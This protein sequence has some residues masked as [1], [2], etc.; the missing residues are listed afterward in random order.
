MFKKGKL[1][2]HFIAPFIKKQSTFEEMH[3]RV[4]ETQFLRQYD[5][6]SGQDDLVKKIKVLFGIGSKA[7]NEIEFYLR[8]I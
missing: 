7:F 1:F 2:D 6:N 5:N 8:Q 4:A 3:R